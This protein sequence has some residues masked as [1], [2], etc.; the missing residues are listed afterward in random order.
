[1]SFD[2]TWLCLFKM[3]AVYLEKAPPKVSRRHIVIPWP[4]IGIIYSL[5]AHINGIIISAATTSTINTNSDTTLPLLILRL[6]LLLVLSPL[7]ILSPLLVCARPFACS[8][9]VYYIFCLCEKEFVFVCASM[10]SCA[11]L[12]LNMCMS[13]RL[14]ISLSLC[15]SLCVC[16]SACLLLHATQ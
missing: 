12:C 6:I 11:C 5:V 3:I 13:L 1:M 14:S 9:C 10:T 4:Q 15:V 16:L 7:L 8:V 2:R